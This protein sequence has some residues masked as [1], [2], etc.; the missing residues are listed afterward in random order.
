MQM[1]GESHAEVYG[2]R[3]GL[4]FGGIVECHLGRIFFGKLIK[5]FGGSDFPALKNNGI[6]VIQTL[7]GHHWSAEADIGNW[8]FCYGKEI[9]IHFAHPGGKVAFKTTY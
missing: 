1:Q 9:L 6:A 2:C 3:D 4:V 8:L 5:R 7:F